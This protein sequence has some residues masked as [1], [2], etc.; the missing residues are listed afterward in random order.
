MAA[1]LFPMLM[2]WTVSLVLFHELPIFVT[3]LDAS[4]VA[5]T[6]K[7][8]GQRPKPR[9]ADETSEDVFGSRGT[10]GAPEIKFW[11]SSCA[12]AAFTR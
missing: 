8:A 11:R 10:S 7:T 3:D 9:L 2:V 6:H 12:L 1:V 5:P 4:P